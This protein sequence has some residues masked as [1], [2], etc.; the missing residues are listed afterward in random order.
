R[1]RSP[2]GNVGHAERNMNRDC[3]DRKTAAGGI[4]ALEDGSPLGFFA[5]QDDAQQ[6]FEELYPPAARADWVLSGSNALG[7]L[8]DGE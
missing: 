2:T 4:K 6:A 5:V 7:A 3:P 1:Y 8:L